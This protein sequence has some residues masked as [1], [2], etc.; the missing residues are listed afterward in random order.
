MR[1]SPL[2]P[3]R[4]A[5][6]GLGHCG[7]PRYPERERRTNCNESS[8]GKGKNGKPTALTIWGWTEQPGSPCGLCP[9]ENPVGLGPSVPQG[10]APGVP[11]PSPP[12]EAAFWLERRR[13]R[14]FA[15]GAG[16][17]LWVSSL[18]GST[19]FF[20]KLGFCPFCFLLVA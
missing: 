8:H 18:A 5:P 16:D 20:N 7:C 11:L 15:W 10:L 12:G 19:V 2:T 14:G 4:V 6:G 3:L 17:W 1:P 13:A 9:G